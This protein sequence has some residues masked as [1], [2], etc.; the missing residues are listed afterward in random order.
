M[1]QHDNAVA[2]EQLQTG[3]LDGTGRQYVY[4]L[5]TPHSHRGL[6][7]PFCLLPL[8]WGAKVGVIQ[9]AC[10]QAPS[11]PASKTPRLSPP[12]TAV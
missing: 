6:A 4:F 12:T 11:A 9:G 7:L 3:L 2:L 1:K 5:L 8:S 10:S